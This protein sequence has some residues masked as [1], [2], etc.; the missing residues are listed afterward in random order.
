D[1]EAVYPRHLQIQD[2]AVHW[3][4]GHHLEGLLPVGGGHGL[5]PAQ[6]LEVVGVLLGHGSD[7][8]YHQDQCHVAV[9]RSMMKRVPE[10]GAVS[11]RSD[12]WRSST[13]LRTMERPSPVPPGL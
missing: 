13:S 2:D 10:P 8:V 12:P 3:L 6:P 7:V 5:E 1:A 9:G 11:T 4:A